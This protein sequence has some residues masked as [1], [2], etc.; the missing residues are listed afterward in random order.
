MYCRLPGRCTAGYQEG[1]LQVTRKV[2]CRLPGRCTVGYQEGV[3]QVTRKVYCRLPGRYT[4]GP[5]HRPR[6]VVALCGD[7]CRQFPLQCTSLLPYIKASTIL[8]HVHQRRVY[9]VCFLSLRRA[10]LVPTSNTCAN[11]K[12][13]EVKNI[14]NRILIR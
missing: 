4:A 13:N 9:F 11:G 8:S 1:V 3:L 7:H 5:T 6:Q 14:E 12:G 10:V 2:Y